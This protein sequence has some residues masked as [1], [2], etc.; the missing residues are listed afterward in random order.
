MPNENFSEK[1]IEELEQAHAHTKNIE[2]DIKKR[3]ADLEAI[4]IAING[5]IERFKSA[6]LVLQNFIQGARDRGWLSRA[7]VEDLEREENQKRK[8]EKLAREA[9]EK[10]KQAADEALSGTSKEMEKNEEV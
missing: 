8:L 6:L 2:S 10:K 5:D 3:E 1:E 7:E 4:T 9:E